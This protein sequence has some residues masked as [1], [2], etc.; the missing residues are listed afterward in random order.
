MLG[1]WFIAV[2][3]DDSG[4]LR[5]CV[6]G[7]L[8]PC[9]G[10][11]SSCSLDFCLPSPVTTSLLLVSLSDAE[12]TCGMSVFCECGSFW[13]KADPIVS[14]LKSLSHGRFLLRVSDSVVSDDIFR[15]P[16]FVCALS[17]VS[18]IGREVLCSVLSSV[19]PKIFSID[20]LVFSFGCFRRTFSCERYLSVEKE[21]SRDFV[22]LSPFSVCAFDSFEVLSSF[23]V[24]P[25]TPET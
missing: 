15:G 18:I 8:C 9:I 17:N 4:S 1:V 14:K 11:P 22:G 16:D 5:A 2:S 6:F 24:A 23:S 7:S 3:G 10:W 19:L 13:G 20:L 12:R 21:L 25:V